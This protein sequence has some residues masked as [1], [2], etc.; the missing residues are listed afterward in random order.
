MPNSS[1]GTEFNEKS[2]EKVQG[3]AKLN[4]FDSRYVD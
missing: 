1:P 2:D 3:L 4:A